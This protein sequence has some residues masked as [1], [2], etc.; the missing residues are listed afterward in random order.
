MFG[1]AV[2]HILYSDSESSSRTTG[3]TEQ[4]KVHMF[5]KRRYSAVLM[6]CII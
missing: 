3:S 5:M 1:S 4:C 2:R 6:N